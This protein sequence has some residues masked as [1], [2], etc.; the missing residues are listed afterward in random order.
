MGLLCKVFMSDY[1]E[2]I[3]LNPD[4]PLYDNQCEQSTAVFERIFISPLNISHKTPNQEKN[5]QQTSCIAITQ[6][7]NKKKAKIKNPL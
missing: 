7:L 4:L 1:L 2:M 5:I 3:Y 6:I